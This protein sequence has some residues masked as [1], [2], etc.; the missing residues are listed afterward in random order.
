MI[1]SLHAFLSITAL[2]AAT[3][4]LGQAPPLPTPD[5]SFFAQ[6]RKSLMLACAETA[7]TLGADGNVETA[8]Y[9]WVQLAAGNRDKADAFFHEAIKKGSLFI[10]S[11]GHV[12]TTA[13]GHPISTGKF[14]RAEGAGAET[15]RVI[16]LAWLRQGHK[17]EALRAYEVMGEADDEGMFLNKK[18]SM[19]RAAVDLLDAGLVKE[20]TRYMDK[21]YLADVED[22]DDFATFAEAA[23]AAGE[24]ALAARYFAYAVKADPKDSGLW[25]RISQAYADYLRK[26]PAAP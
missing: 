7:R 25:I 15:Y 17:D 10:T 2:L 20:A 13:D 6:D 23:L 12:G 9:G 19:A 14:T 1:R 18:G 22:S 3:A 21:V 16:G 8:E 26:H 5:K 11:S 24:R 4:A